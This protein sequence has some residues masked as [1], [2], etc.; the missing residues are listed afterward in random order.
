MADFKKQRPNFLRI[1][2]TEEIDAPISQDVFAR[3]AWQNTLFANENQS[4][5]I[6][7]NVDALTENDF[8]TTIEGSKPRYVFDVRRVPR[9]DIGSL[10][11]REAFA[12]FKSHAAQYLD[13][14]SLH[15][16]LP[17]HQSSS[18]KA[19]ETIWDTQLARALKGPIAILVDSNQFDEEYVAQLLEGLPMESH[20][21]WDVLRLPF[22][23][24]SASRADTARSVIFISHANPEDNVFTLWLTQ[25]L[26]LLGFEVWSDVN[27]LKAG[28]KFW[29]DIE[30]TIRLKSAKV[31]VVLSKS[32][33]TKANLLDEIDLAVRV[34]RAENITR[35]VIPV[36]IDEIGFDQ[37]RANLARK[38]IIDFNQ[39]WANGL[40]A[41]LG[42][43]DEDRVP[44][45]TGTLSSA[46]S[47][48]QLSGIHKVP[49]V[50][51]KPEL[52]TSN[53]LL[54][55]DLPD[56][57]RL[58]DVAAPGDKIESIARSLRV[59]SF[60][61]LRLIGSFSSGEGIAG[62]DS[63]LPALTEKYAIPFDD[64]LR[65]ASSELPGMRARDAHNL[66]ISM[67]R[68]AWDFEMD[69]RGLRS[70]A[71]ASN[72]LAW[73][74]PTDFI[75]NNKVQFLDATGK[76]RR[77]S[78]VG[79]SERRK[80]FWH[81]AVEARPVLG[82]HPRFVLRQH[83][84]F[85]ADGST[86]LVSKDRMHALRR[87]FCKSWWNDRW[88]DMLIA[89]VTWLSPSAGLNLGGDTVLGL[90]DQLFSLWSPLSLE[91]DAKVSVESTDEI[92]EDDELSADDDVVD[93]E[94]TSEFSPSE[95]SEV[96]G[97]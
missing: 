94:D 58:F 87:R 53:W 7:L 80:V 65:G 92:V 5:V 60:K 63:A 96:I 81:F 21:P 93:L 29:E 64:F 41:V 45:R 14:S 90:D 51:H 84:I 9:F 38:N 12:L 50:T 25:Q 97:E 33:Q 74:M 72:A 89:F 30:S 23:K 91:D 47:K 11:R 71:M 52:L 56:V 70:F 36:R 22:V 68:Q 32:S 82:A 59:P 17:S 19:A 54:I 34:E 40:M 48:I 16:G 2:E 79:W 78:L 76:K 1:V 26:T 3:P 24:A 75:P 13:L 86:P 83:I 66:S 35:F 8:R 31:I 61:Y 6:F 85:T 44:K 20:E 27:N 42:A 55:N 43:L 39:N 62:P 49:L 4:L 18:A 77:K 46:M 37:V 10:N 67:L 95:T 88:R 73:Y 28:D 15:R 69:K 57:I